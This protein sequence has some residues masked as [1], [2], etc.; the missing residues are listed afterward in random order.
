M[1]EHL[2]VV[3]GKILSY[4]RTISLRE[5]PVQ[6][7]LRTITNS[8]PESGWEVAPEQAQFLSLIVEIIGAKKILE[9]GTFTGTS[10]LAMGL[11]LPIDGK[12]ITCD[13]EPAFTHIAEKYWAKA[14]IRHK[15]E[16]RIGNALDTLNTLHHEFSNEYFDMAF[17]DANKKNYDEYYEITLKLI[18]VGGV[19]V[20]DNV[21]WQGAVLDKNNNEK[22]TVAIRNLNAK[23]LR[24]ERVSISMLPMNDGLT[25]LC[26]QKQI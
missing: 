11:V 23:L 26:K 25:L 17:I 18:R 16:L 2:P 12:I 1:S 13:M 19:I 14:G 24:D 9:I 8:L 3:G 7:K 5:S 22:S 10:S 6:K 4:L 20:I 15:I 21:F